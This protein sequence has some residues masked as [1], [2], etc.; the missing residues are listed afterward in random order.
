MAL[1]CLVLFLFRI[2]LFATIILSWFPIAPGSGLASVYSVCFRI[3]DPV[4]G[5]IRRA[6]PA[7]RIG[8]LALDL[9]PFIVIIGLSILG[10]IVGC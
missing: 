3:T 6:V 10:S 2:V 8:G 5:P 9:S 1:V 7:L 4:L